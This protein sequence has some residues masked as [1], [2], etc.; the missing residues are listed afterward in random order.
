MSDIPY[1]QY[2]DQIADDF[3]LHDA[4]GQILDVGAQACL[5][6]GYKYD[7][8]LRLNMSALSAS[9][10]PKALEQLWERMEPGRS[11][12]WLDKLRRQDGSLMPVEMQISCQCVDGQKRFFTLSRDTSERIGREAE[13]RALNSQLERQVQESTRQWKDTARLLDAVLSD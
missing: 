7:D 4:R 1:R 13:I 11:T 10:A 3:I 6:L 9:H 2:L 8:L 12:R 5:S